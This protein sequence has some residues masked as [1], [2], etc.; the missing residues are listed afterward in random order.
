MTLLLP[1]GVT[2]LYDLPYNIWNAIRAAL[3][4]LGFDELPADETPDRDIWLDNRAMRKHWKKVEEIR[5][6]KMG[7][8]P[9]RYS[10]E[11]IE[12]PVSRNAAMDDLFEK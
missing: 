5:R 6:V 9:D 3:G 4:F 8:K 2:T 12:G 1:A 10:D 11:P 7:G